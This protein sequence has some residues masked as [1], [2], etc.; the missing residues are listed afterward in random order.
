MVIFDKIRR[1]RIRKVYS[2]FPNIDYVSNRFYMT[3]GELISM[4]KRGNPSEE[5][6]SIIE[7]NHDEIIRL[8]ETREMNIDKIAKKFS[9]TRE[10]V[11]TLLVNEN[12]DLSRED[13]MTQEELAIANVWKESNGTITNKQLQDKFGVG[14][15]KVAKALR[16]FGA[17]NAKTNK[18]SDNEKSEIIKSYREGLGAYVIADKYSADPRTIYA[19]LEEAG[20]PMRDRSE[21]ASLNLERREDSNYKQVFQDYRKWPR[22][23]EKI[24]MRDNYHCVMCQVD[25]EKHPEEEAQIN[26]VRVKELYPSL[27]YEEKNLVT[28]CRK[29]H[30]TEVGDKEAE[31]EDFFDEILAA[32]Y[33]NVNFEAYVK[34]AKLQ[35]IDIDL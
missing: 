24:K 25:F 7:D 32:K 28:L 22:M 3:S 10:N 33:S 6:V 12:I 23:C 34:W 13:I 26:H 29:C 11:V 21:A 16:K 19:V 8:F 17:E 4:L 14:S 2:E 20:V 30:L 27:E 35:R 18:F 1:W 5:K 9:I 15:Y 31:Y